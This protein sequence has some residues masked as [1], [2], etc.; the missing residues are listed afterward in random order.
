MNC[1]LSL[2]I[3]KN[4]YFIFT[5]LGLAIVGLWFANFKVW[6]NIILNILFLLLYGYMV[7]LWMGRILKRLGFKRYCFVFGVFG[8]FFLVSFGMAI[9]IVLYKVFPW[10]LFLLLGILVL[11]FSIWQKKVKSLI[12]VSK[13]SFSIENKKL[14]YFW[15]ALVVIGFLILIQAR[16]GKYIRS[17][18]VTISNVYIYV[19][20]GIVLVLGFLAF[21]GISTKK[22]I[23]LLIVSSL[24]MHCFVMIPYKAGFGG[25]KWRHI[26]AERSLMQG[27]VYK[28]TLFG[29]G[30]SYKKFGSLKIPEVLIVGNKTSYS[31][32]WGGV[33]ALSWLSGMDVFW[34]DLFLGGIL[35]AVFL[36]FLLIELA[37]FFSKKKK[38]LYLFLIGS[39]CFYP[40]II[41]GSITTP[42]SFGFLLFLFL[43]ILIMKYYS[44]QR[45]FS[46]LWPVLVI[47]LPLLYLNYVLYLV[48]FLEILLLA[49]LFKKKKF[50][51]VGFLIFVASLLLIFSFPFLD[52]FKNM[53][54]FKIGMNLKEVFNS[55]KEFLGQILVSKSLF[56]NVYGFEQDGWLYS[57]VG[58]NL[59]DSVLGGIVAWN[60]VLTP[61]VWLISLFGFSQSKKFKKPSLGKMFFLILVVSLFSQMIASFF[62]KGNHI[63]SKRLVLFVSFLF[64]IFLSWGLF[65]FFKSKL[66]SKKAKMVTIVIF[67]ALLSTTVYISGP[68]FRMVTS[69]E[70]E[71]SKYLWQKLKDKEEPYCVLGNTW[72][73]LSLE[74][75]SAREVTTGGFP[76]YF[77]YQQPERV[78]LFYNM[79]QNPSIKYLEKALSVTGAKACYF[80]TEKRWIN[81]GERDWIIKRLDR[82]MGNHKEIGDVKIWYYEPLKVN[83]N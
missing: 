70:Y 51:G 3:Q 14:F 81:Y 74:A 67:L 27:E 56:P 37:R 54:W 21:K 34:I 32:M 20:M 79:N 44:N 29:K 11:I 68:K 4:K 47:S 48:L 33:I 58:R 73:L 31:N 36:P 77:E 22:F 72:P 53:S 1:N 76:Y 40:L 46:K 15:L 75:V 10:H 60:I 65:R 82:I 55:V 6:Q 38:F 59:S 12:K 35:F 43:L 45:P 9:P 8:L 26:G 66:F 50:K 23:L 7:G 64:L 17:P 18:W 61:L 63:F 19:W 28:P 57:T 24:L 78:Q 80:M 2:K 83:N 30:A 52:T 69:D 39:M 49:V 42:R 5:L 16:T 71:T 62:M 41:Y 25:D 13:V